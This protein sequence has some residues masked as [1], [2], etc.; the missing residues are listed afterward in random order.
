MKFVRLGAV[1]K[2]HERLRPFNLESQL[3]DLL[4]DAGR[5]SNNSIAETARL[6]DFLDEAMSHAVSPPF[7][8]HLLMRAL[9]N[10][11]Q[12]R[13]FVAVAGRGGLHGS[14]RRWRRQSATRR[15]RSTHLRCGGSRRGHPAPPPHG[16]RRSAPAETRG[17]GPIRSRR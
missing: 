12:F 2:V 7:P 15:T 17:R 5:S 4:R 9:P 3:S 14:G 13:V 6:V 1:E 11:R 10:L 8:I 16:H